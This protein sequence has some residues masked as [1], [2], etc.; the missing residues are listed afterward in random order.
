MKPNLTHWTFNFHRRWCKSSRV[1]PRCANGAGRAADVGGGHLT[2]AVLHRHVK[3]LWVWQTM[4]PLWERTPSLLDSLLSFRPSTNL[5]CMSG[6]LAPG[7]CTVFEERVF[8]TTRPTVSMLQE[9]IRDS[10]RLFK[11]ALKPQWQKRTQT[12]GFWR[13]AGFFFLLLSCAKSSLGIQSPNL[14]FITVCTLADSL[15]RFSHKIH[16][17]DFAVQ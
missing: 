1:A 2:L 16:P 3:P 10:Q 17:A 6:L 12:I 13:R 5:H 7:L 4:A 11:H 15:N 8:P 14:W 9:W